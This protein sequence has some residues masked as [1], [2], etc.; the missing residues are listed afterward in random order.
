[1][2]LRAGVSL[3]WALL[4]V[5]PA[6]AASSVRDEVSVDR[7]QS[8]A[9]N[10]RAGAFTNLFGASVDVGEDWVFSGTAMVRLES[11]TAAPVPLAGVQDTGGTLTS[12]SLGA[13]WDVIDH[14]SVGVRGWLSPR[15]TTRSAATFSVPRNGRP[16]NAVAPVDVSGSSVAIDLTADYD[17]GG[18]SDFEWALGGGI[19]L[20]R[21]STSQIVPGLVFAD[22]TVFSAQQTRDACAVRRPR[23]PT[24]LLRAL[25]GNSDDL[26]SLRLSLSGTVTVSRNTDFALSGDYHLY[27]SDPAQF[28]YFGLSA[29]QTQS[30]GIGAPIAP[31]LFVVRPEVTRRFGDFSLRLWVQVGRYAPGVARSTA[32]IGARAQMRFGSSFRVWVGLSGRNDVDLQD[33]SAKAGS[34]TVGGAW[35]F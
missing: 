29:T 34:V 2:R 21:D 1:V 9:Q 19:T 35:R 15:S 16:A 24:A 13:D 26:G 23:C 8:T 5:A 3:S 27:D 18:F 30:E 17:S 22:G 7:V 4:A 12:F 14:Y 11:A 25:D 33:E 32:G 6:A 31:L 28:G 20:G 10:P